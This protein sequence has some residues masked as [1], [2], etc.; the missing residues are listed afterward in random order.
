MAGHEHHVKSQVYAE[1]LYGGAYVGLLYSVQRAG[2]TRHSESELAEGVQGEPPSGQ[3][4]VLCAGESD[5][6][7]LHEGRRGGGS[8]ACG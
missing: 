4:H 5:D 8:R 2:V 1:T 6:G 3:R 7:Q